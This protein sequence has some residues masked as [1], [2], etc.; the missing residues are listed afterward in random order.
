MRRVARLP[1]LLG[2]GAFVVGTCELALAGLIPELGR[3]LELSVAAAGQVV[4]VFG[5]TAA[6]AGPI[7]SVATARFSRRAVLLLALTL[8]VAGTALSALSWSFGSLLVAQMIAACGAGSFLPTATVVAA[9][10]VPESRRG[11]AVA[12]VTTG[13]T[14]AIAAGAPL[15]TAVAA[16]ASWRLTMAALAGLAVAVA[17]L[18]L[19]RVPSVRMPEQT[20]VGLRDR[21]SP[22]GDSRVL[23]LLATTVAAFTASYV[24]IRTSR[25]SLPRRPDD[26]RIGS[27]G[28]R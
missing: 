2:T 6:A 26:S 1:V 20:P 21:L 9:G 18:V 12:T 7:V 5:V 16:L 10:L 25:S 28:G 23:A 19:A 22:L 14:V 3:A 17:G 24:P 13:M 8:Y 15:G 27:A 11:S 4:T